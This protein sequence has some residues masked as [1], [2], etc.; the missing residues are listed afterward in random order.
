M[1]ISPL[2]AVRLVLRQKL[3]VNGS[4]VAGVSITDFLIRDLT[5][6]EACDLSRA[7]STA[8]VE[9]VW[10]RGLRAVESER[11]SVGKMLHTEPRYAR[12]AF[13]RAMVGAVRRADL[14]MVQWLRGRFPDCP[15]Y[16]D[17]LDEACTYGQL[18]ALQLLHCVGNGNDF[19]WSS[20]MPISAAEFGHWDVIHWVYDLYPGLSLDGMLEFALREN[21]LEEVKW[22]TAHADS[23]DV[24]DTRIP[25]SEET[26]PA[27]KDCVRC[28]V[29]RGLAVQ[30][31]VEEFLPIAAEAGDLPFLQWL[32]SYE[33]DDA[34]YVYW[35]ALE[36]AC[37]HGHIQV[38][39]CLLARTE[40]LGLP[41]DPSGIMC[42]AARGGQL[43]MVQWVYE[44]YGR[45]AAANLFEAKRGLTALEAAA[46]NGH[47]VVVQFLH[48]IDASLKTKRKQQA[49]LVSGPTCT[50]KAM[51]AAARAGHLAVVEWLHTNRSEGCTV[52][53]MDGAAVNG[54]LDVV[55]WLHANRAEGCTAT[56]MDGAAA[57][58]HLDVVKWL[59]ANRS[60]GCTSAAMDGAAGRAYHEPGSPGNVSYC[61]VDKRPDSFVEAQIMMLEWLRTNRKLG[62]SSVALYW[63]SHNG[64]LTVLQWL[65]VNTTARPSLYPMEVT[66]G[67]GR[68]D[69]V[70]W[71]YESYPEC[72]TDAAVSSAMNSAANTG[73]LEVV[74]WL[75]SNLPGSTPGRVLIT[76]A[77]HS[78]LLPTRRQLEVVRLLLPNAAAVDV[79]TAMRK[80]MDERQFEIVLLLHTEHPTLTSDALQDITTEQRFV[81]PSDSDSEVS[82]WIVENYPFDL[83]SK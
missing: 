28:L 34:K 75:R 54:N 77:G 4:D 29:A 73:R 44:L 13:T 82:A 7:G 79:A 65:R 9:F 31:V 5:L 52:N 38:V 76:A 24:G 70:K 83:E 67:A 35:L 59:H 57:K 19:R 81:D 16:E 40:E 48:R 43:A 11:W 42:A 37:E 66:A 17:V 50:T 30:D 49:V 23:F 33:L 68:L 56:A 26:W 74:K 41:S 2:A 72:C 51:D 47:L 21:N 22:L 58:G 71:L 61:F 10:T 15:I 3:P 1:E 69:I 60:E 8:L 53:A 80:A 12:W 36:R 39:R 63:A 62:C 25:Y 14:A 20:Q 55:K 46:E 27:Q 78:R 18:E 6:R 64:N 45:K 32:T